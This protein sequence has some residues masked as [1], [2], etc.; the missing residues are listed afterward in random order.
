MACIFY[1]DLYFVDVGPFFAYS[2]PVHSFHTRRDRL[3]AL[4]ACRLH[5]AAIH[6]AS[7]LG[8]GRTLTLPC[9][10]NNAGPIKSSFAAQHPHRAELDSMLS[11]CG[12]LLFTVSMIFSGV[13]WNPVNGKMAGIGCF[14]SAAI[15]LYVG[16]GTFFFYFA[17][18][19]AWAPEFGGRKWVLRGRDWPSQNGVFGFG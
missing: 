14:V 19:L 15:A 2:L 8:P 10:W 1:P 4:T 9:G 7:P 11:L 17:A 3:A 18:V 6:R 13:K 16:T 5:G 12:G